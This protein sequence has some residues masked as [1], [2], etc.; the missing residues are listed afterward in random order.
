LKFIINTLYQPSRLQFFTTIYDTLYIRPQ[1]PILT[2][3]STA[4]L[5]PFLDERIATFQDCLHATLFK[6]AELFVKNWKDQK[7]AILKEHLARVTSK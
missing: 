2:L 4:K 6:M 1:T 5:K 7:I 3:F